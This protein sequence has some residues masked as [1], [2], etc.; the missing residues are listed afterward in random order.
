MP[1]SSRRS[2]KTSYAWKV[3]VHVF[4][5]IQSMAKESMEKHDESEDTVYTGIFL[6]TERRSLGLLSMEQKIGLWFNS[7]TDK[8]VHHGHMCVTALKKYDSFKYILPH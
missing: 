6:H 5:F 8:R 3:H 7:V 2:K 4:F 1:I